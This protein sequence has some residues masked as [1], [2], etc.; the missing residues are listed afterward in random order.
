L[1]GKDRRL[2][3]RDEMVGLFESVAADAIKRLPKLALTALLGYHPRP[4]YEGWP[5]PHV[6]RMSTAEDH[7]P[8]SIL[9]SAEPRNRTLHDSSCLSSTD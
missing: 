5:M 2:L 3:V 9:I 4:I 7:D 8:I 6:L 1:V